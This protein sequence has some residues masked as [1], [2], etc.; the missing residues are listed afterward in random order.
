MFQAL[1]QIISYDTIHDRRW[2]FENFLPKFSQMLKDPTMHV[3]KVCTGKR[4]MLTLESNE[5][6]DGKLH[7][8][9][10]CTH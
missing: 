10:R 6:F 9:I 4:V 7:L 3:R 5:L 1:C 8:R 2:L